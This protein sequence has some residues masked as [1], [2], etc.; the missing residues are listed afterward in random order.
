MTLAIDGVFLLFIS[1]YHVISFSVV[2]GMFVIFIILL[3]IGIR[4]DIL[5]FLFLGDS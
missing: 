4:F 2:F 3:S 5:L 1:T